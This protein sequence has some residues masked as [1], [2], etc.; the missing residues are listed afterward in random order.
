MVGNFSHLRMANSSYY[1]TDMDN[2]VIFQSPS[3]DSPPAASQTPQNP[4]AVPQQPT[5][6]TVAPAVV[7][8]AQTETDNAPLS[9]NP[10]EPADPFTT[11]QSVIPPPPA[12]PPPPPPPPP[13]PAPTGIA[14]VVDFLTNN[15]LLV[16]IGVVVLLFIIVASL[17]A[18]GKKSAG[19]VE[20]TY[21]GLWEDPHVMGLIIDDF[22][23]K[24]PNIKINYVKEDSTNY[25]AKLL[26]RIPEGNG[27]DIFRYHNTWVPML[28]PDLLPL[29]TTAIS[30]DEF[31]KVFYPAAQDDLVYNGAI[32]GIP[33]EMDTLALFVND[34]MF[35]AGGYTP[36][37]TWDQVLSL[38]PKLTVKDSDKKI[39]KAGIALGTYENITHAPDILSSLFYIQGVDLKHLQASARNSQRALEFYWGYAIGD[40]NVWDTTLDNSVT[41]FGK[42][43]LA[44]YFGYSYDI[45][46]MKA[47]NP[48]LKFSVYPMP[49]SPGR[50]VTVASY[51]VE[52]V[53]SKTKHPSEAMLFMNYL[54]QKETEQKLFSEAS[55]T[56]LFG[57][58]YARVD[59]ADSLKDSPYLSTFIAQAKYAK[60]SIFAGE[61]G[62]QS[63]INAKLNGYLR[64]AI[65]AGAANLSSQKSIEDLDSGVSQVLGDYGIH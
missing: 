7:P 3:G 26:A 30:K 31:Q 46:T 60:S 15:L 13:P 5:V 10:P 11:I 33:M 6:Q 16:I 24:Y 51:W 34:D 57:E 47:I 39:Q 40:Q 54:S 27:P 42:G 12:E 36:P 65:N 1:T 8:P 44:M 53:S 2:N 49:H 48:D 56:R 55:K 52:G 22:Q 14:G 45:F 19:N 35:Q 62:D 38:A 41:A 9:T 37:E 58:P 64:N 29:S 59:L 25:A 21:W 28:K 17:L 18:G 63:G 61:T 4:A 50:T 32:Y 43:N 23:R 20:L